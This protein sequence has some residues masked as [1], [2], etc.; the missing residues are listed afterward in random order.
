MKYLV[1][2]DGSENGEA[3][4]NRAKDVYVGHRDEL[5][6]LFVHS[7]DEEK[8]LKEIDIVQHYS[9][10]LINNFIVKFIFIF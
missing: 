10:V 2:V 9:K 3:A 5:L 4:F 1:C 7:G 8:R 6:I